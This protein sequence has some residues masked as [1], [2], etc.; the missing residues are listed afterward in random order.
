MIALGLGG[1]EVSDKRFMHRVLRDDVARD[2]SAGGDDWMAGGNL[3][4][5]LTGLHREGHV[6]PHQARAVSLFLDDMRRCHGSSAGL[7]CQMD[8]DKI[9]NSGKAMFLTS[10]G[11]LFAFERMQSLLASLHPHERQ[12]LAF[13]ITCKEKDRGSLADYGRRHSAYEPAKTTRAW[14]VGRIS[15]LLESIAERYR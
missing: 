10:H 12:T 7:V 9:G 5:V 6:R 15:A 13:L 3:G 4:D 14:S 11:D 8:N 2:M 1:F